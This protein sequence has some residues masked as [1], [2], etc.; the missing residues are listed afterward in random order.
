[1][2]RAWLMSVVLLG[3]VLLGGCDAQDKAQYEGVLTQIEQRSQELQPVVS[4][5]ERTVA[6]QEAY[7]ESLPESSSMREPAAESLAEAERV[8][9][10]A[11]DRMDQLRTAAGDVKA[12]IEAI[13]AGEE[14]DIGTGLQLVGGTGGAVAPFL[15]APWNGMALGVSALLTGLAGAFGAAK[16]KQAKEKERERR[17]AR[18]EAHRE[19]GTAELM[20][21]RADEVERGFGEVVRAIEIAKQ[22]G[23]GKVDFTDEK[24]KAILRASMGEPTQRQVDRHRPATKR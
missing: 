3:L 23:G 24:T 6:E 5:L 22:A 15:P 10:E 19:R 14:P 1:M 17:Q 9:S 7:F 11:Q 16:G 12:A 4:E 20:S 8:L 2:K 13:E 21:R 18:G